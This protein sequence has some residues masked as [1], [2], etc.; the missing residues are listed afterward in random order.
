M[1]R[2]SMPNQMTK[3]TEIREEIRDAHQKALANWRQEIADGNLS[4]ST[5]FSQYNWIQRVKVMPNTTVD[6]SYRVF[7]PKKIIRS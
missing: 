6:Y 1:R 7:I 4:S 2:W 5:S 3:G